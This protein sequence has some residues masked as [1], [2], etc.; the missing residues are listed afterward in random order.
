ML[1]L[2]RTAR[3]HSAGLPVV[4][5]SSI[6]AA[7]ATTRRSRPD[8]LNTPAATSA[9]TMHIPTAALSALSATCL[10][11]G[12]HGAHREV[13]RAGSTPSRRCPF[14]FGPLPPARA[15]RRPTRTLVVQADDLRATVERMLSA[16]GSDDAEAQAVASNLVLSNLKG[17]DSHGVGYL[18]RYIRG[19]KEG[20]IALNAKAAVVAETPTTVLL[21]GGVGFGQCL[22]KQAMGLGIPKALEQGVAVVGMRNSHH[23]ARI[24]ACMGGAVRGRGAHQR[25]L[26]KRGRARAARRAAQRLRRAARHQPV[27][28]RLP[29]RPL[30][31]CHP[32]AGTKEFSAPTLR[33]GPDGKHIVL[34]YATSEP[35][36]NW[37]HSLPRQLCSSL[38]HLTAATPPHPPPL[39]LHL[40]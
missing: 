6:R 11:V 28:R 22:G 21:D 35:Y 12:S 25:A 3:R 33:S 38:V 17:H 5:T 26:H 20:L 1:V 18:P 8:A 36:R 29:V 15:Q 9:A 13:H 14:R 37:R 40:A 39:T 31:P 30:P 7:P 4:S 2:G 27:H 32:T 24:G 10:F 34:D 16:A 23:L 19:A